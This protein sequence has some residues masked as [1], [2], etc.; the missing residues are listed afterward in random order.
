M[1]VYLTLTAGNQV[2]QAFFC[3]TW[4]ASAGYPVVC[5]RFRDR[6]IAKDQESRSLSMTRRLA[7]VKMLAN[8]RWPFVLCPVSSSRL[9]VVTSAGAEMVDWL[10]SLADAESMRLPAGK[11]ASSVVSAGTA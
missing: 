9:F 8:H 4:I 11:L 7:K 1:K 5:G 3:V 10:Q 2:H 6:S